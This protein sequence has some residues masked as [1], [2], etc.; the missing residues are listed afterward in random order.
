MA[1]AR[2]KGGVEVGKKL[3]RVQGGRQGMGKR[4]YFRSGWSR[5]IHGRVTA[6]S[7]SRQQMAKKT[8]NDGKRLPLAKII[9][10]GP[11]QRPARWQISFCDKDQFTKN[12]SG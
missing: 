4:M 7:Y 10:D 12:K 6:A 2:V 11:F 9:R 3:S 1:G 8:K 5:R